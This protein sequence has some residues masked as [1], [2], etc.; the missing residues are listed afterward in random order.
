MNQQ[1]F[2]T[3]S[4][5]I[6]G[7]GQIIRCEWNA[8]QVVG[9]TLERFQEAEKMANEAMAKADEYKKQLVEHGILQPQL[10][11]E[12]QIAALNVR[13]GDLSSKLSALLSAVQNSQQVQHKKEDA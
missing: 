7:T 8:Q 4:A 9:V 1:F 10:S 2:Q 12:E 13:V 3:F 5:C 11:T 6:D